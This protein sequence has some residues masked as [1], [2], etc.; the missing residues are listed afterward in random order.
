MLA[1]HMLAFHMFCHQ[2]SSNAVNIAREPLNRYFKTL[3]TAASGWAA[4][5]SS[6]DYVG[7]N[8]MPDRLSKENFDTQVAKGAAWVGPP[9][10]IP[11]QLQNNF[12]SLTVEDAEASMRLFSARVMPNFR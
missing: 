10:E 8:S 7:Y 2:D 11:A 4:G 6:T 1:F 5:V 12:N 9:S 3:S